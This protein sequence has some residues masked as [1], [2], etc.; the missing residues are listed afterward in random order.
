MGNNNIGVLSEKGVRDKWEQQ[1]LD[2]KIDKQRYNCNSEKIARLYKAKSELE[3]NKSVVSKRISEL[4][5]YAVVFRYNKWK[6]DSGDKCEIYIRDMIIKK[7]ETYL[8]SIVEGIQQIKKEIDRLEEQ[9]DILKCD[10][11]SKK[12]I[13]VLSKKMEIGC[14]KYARD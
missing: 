12:Y 4:K 11:M 5:K 6:A 2:D 8:D 10:I 3:R 13:Q 1:Q 14:E 9:N 7:Y